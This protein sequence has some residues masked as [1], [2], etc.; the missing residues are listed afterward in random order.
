MT[1]RSSRVEKKDVASDR[2]LPASWRAYTARLLAN[3]ASKFGSGF[4]L[5]DEIL[6][7][8]P[9]LRKIIHAKLLKVCSIIHCNLVMEYA[10]KMRSPFH[11]R[12]STKLKV[13]KPTRA[14]GWRV[15]ADPEL[16]SF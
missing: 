11:L 4:R 9:I 16:F 5:R 8:F 2:I 1:F 13:T 6:S 3:S 14:P 12:A 7:G 15:M 10:T